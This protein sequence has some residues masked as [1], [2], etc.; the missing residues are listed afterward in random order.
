MTT[1]EA[2]RDGMTGVERAATRGSSSVLLLAY[3]IAVALAQ[4]LPALASALSGAIMNAVLLVVLLEHRRVFVA[5]RDWPGAATMST[6][7][8]ALALVPL[9]TLLSFAFALDEAS[10]SSYAL[11]GAPAVLAVAL[12][13][14]TLFPERSWRDWAGARVPRQAVAAACGIP[15]GLAG[16]ALLEP[17]PLAGSLSGASL[18]GAAA[19]VFLVAG[20]VEEA[21]FRGLLQ[22]ALAN[23]IGP[24]AGTAAAS[25]L[26]AAAYL[27]TGS[28]EA[29][30][31][32]AIL[33]ALAGAWVQ[34]TGDLA[35]VAA[36][37]GFLA[38]GLIVVW[39][40]LL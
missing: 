13:A 39:P 14:R 4:A 28:A 18:L 31:F 33:G 23:V 38:A 30:A 8:G 3:A 1:I 16:F 17:A 5:Q 20:V 34:R 15:L 32:F 37:H 25:L 21:I 10:V 9:L 26:F 36:A 12:A 19:V 22:P 2:V 40:A 7:L 24:T 29:V 27:G 35:G 6:A 11:I